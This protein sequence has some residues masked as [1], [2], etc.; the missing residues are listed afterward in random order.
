MQFTNPPY[1]I[2]NGVTCADKRYYNW[3][4]V[5][6]LWTIV[7]TGATLRVESC[8]IQRVQVLT[9]PEDKSIQIDGCG[10][11]ISF[12]SLSVMHSHLFLKNV[13]IVAPVGKPGVSFKAPGNNVL[14]VEGMVSI[15]GGTGRCGLE[16]LDGL[17]VVSTRNG[18]LRVMGGSGGGS[19]KADGIRAIGDVTIR[20]NTSATG[21]IGNNGGSGIFSKA[22]ITL[23]ARTQ[24]LGG[25]GALTGGHGVFTPYGGAVIMEE[26]SLRGGESSGLTGGCGLQTGPG[27][28]LRMRTTTGEEGVRYAYEYAAPGIIIGAK[29]MAAGGDCG[30]GVGGCGI[31][32]KGGVSIRGELHATGGAGGVKGG[33]GICA[34]GNIDQ[35]AG[36]EVTA[37]GGSGDSAGADRCEHVEPHKE[38]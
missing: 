35:R 9:L 22:N 17:T 6:Q 24:A 33:P 3:D 11:E 4:D 38:I 13:R 2:G 7:S 23:E 8:P 37:C 36:T 19:S 28:I 34:G 31:C 10:L 15:N 30:F 20:A 26:A 25:S 32:T 14:S 12:L 16:S 21:G 29:T 18:S 1:T 27:I 5:E